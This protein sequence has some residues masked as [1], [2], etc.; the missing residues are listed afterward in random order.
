MSS[1]STS[2]DDLDDASLLHRYARKG[3]VEAMDALI[4]RHAAALRA[5]LRGWFSD[6][7]TLED[8]F[9]ETWSRVLRAPH[10]FRKGSFR[11]W[12]FCIARN[13]VIDY[14]RKHRPELLL[15]RPASDD[16]SEASLVDFLSDES[17]PLPSEILDQQD[18]RES[19]LRAIESLPAA[20]KEVFLL[21]SEDV[22]FREIADHLKIPLNTALGRMHYAIRHLREALS[23]HSSK[24]S[25]HG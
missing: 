21:R 24:D 17:A 11:A 9:Q 23:P 22:S 4:G 2:S 1:S 3:D 10:T 20:Q 25:R 19:L 8:F 14:H 6:P 16:A 7:S 5:F 18:T 13:Q 12:L 15:D